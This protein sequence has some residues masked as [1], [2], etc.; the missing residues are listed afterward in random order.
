MYCSLIPGRTQ[1]PISAYIVLSL[2]WKAGIHF[3]RYTTVDST[4]VLSSHWFSFVW[5]A[6]SGNKFFGVGPNISEKFVPGGTKFRGI[7]NVT[8]MSTTASL[9]VGT[10]RVHQKLTR[11]FLI[12]GCRRIP[13]LSMESSGDTKYPV[14][15]SHRTLVRWGWGLI[16]WGRGGRVGILPW[17]QTGWPRVQGCEM[18]ET[19]GQAWASLTLVSRIAS[20]DDWVC[21]AKSRSACIS[22]EFWACLHEWR[23]SY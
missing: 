18:R 16:E 19:E 12:E 11:V 2:R 7:Q 22:Q 15:L 9:K 6:Y 1:H 4:N 17:H 10:L 13:K 8:R 23:R 5:L 14:T 20:Y 21:I 3:S